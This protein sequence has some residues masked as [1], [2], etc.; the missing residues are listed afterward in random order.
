MMTGGM[1]S[2]RAFLRGVTAAGIA[3][4]FPS[5]ALASSIGVPP[6]LGLESLADTSLLPSAAAVRRHVEEMVR[7]GPRLT[8]SPAHARWIDRLEA[9]LSA[10]GV[11]VSRD[12]FTFTRWSAGRWGL[13]LLEGSGA[14]PV[15][16]SSYVPYSGATG[17]KGIEAELVYLGPTP[18]PSLT[19]DLVDVTS[20]SWAIDRWRREVAAD[21]RSA[22]AGAP[23]GVKGRIVLFDVPV[24][25]LSA[26]DF[27]PLVTY[28]HDPGMTLQAWSDYKRVWLCGAIPEVAMTVLKQ[29][30]AAGVVFALDASRE[31]A[32]G[33]YVP[34]AQPIFGIPALYVDR[35]TGR[36]LRALA[37]GTPR[38]RLTLTAHVDPKAPSDSL[39]G[40]MPGDGSTDEVLILN[41]HTDGQN[42]FEEN[43][44]VALVEMAR[45]FKALG[46]RARRR[47]LVFSLF[48]GHFGPGLPQ[49]EG[50][51]RNHPDLVGRAAACVTVEHFGATEWLDDAHGYHPSG[52]NERGAIWHSQTPI[53]AR[54]IEAMRA[55]DFRRTSAMR[56]AGD[57]MIAVGGPLHKA[58]VPTLSYI[59]GPN[60]LVALGDHLD[61]LDPRLFRSELAWTA[62]IVHRLDK[63]S[64]AALKAGD[65]AGWSHAGGCEPVTPCQ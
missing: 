30:G 10:A 63:L 47:T 44:S 62:D 61:K 52:Y 24:P 29:M 50:F 49:A 57:Y 32:A 43:G 31:C 8:G 3:A 26:G 51:V 12:H 2:R 20:D 14:G 38:A 1:V 28:T 17:P 25:T 23:G 4:T 40:I 13:Q 27:E 39:V 7:F 60:Y 35:D 56:P 9:E 22:L 55:D 58:G 36:R 59:A 48:T 6:A 41:T 33:Q 46:R 16:V 18:V 5:R 19:G 15:P 21:V 37:A 42:A 65:T 34:Y 54:A 45:Y 11:F 53:V 64:A